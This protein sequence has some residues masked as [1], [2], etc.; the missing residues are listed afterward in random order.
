MTVAKAQKILDKDKHLNCD[1]CHED[2]YSVF[3][4]LF[5]FKYEVCPDCILKMY[6]QRRLDS[7]SS[8]IFDVIKKL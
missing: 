4:R 1:K 3:D 2:Y 7:M 5:I 6:C 8:I